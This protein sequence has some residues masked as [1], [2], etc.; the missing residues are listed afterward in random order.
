MKKIKSKKFLESKRKTL[1]DEKKLKQKV[2]KEEE[3]N[4]GWKKSKAKSFC[5]R[6]QVN[7]VSPPVE[8]QTQS[9]ITM[10]MKFL[11]EGEN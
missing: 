2:F 7:D 11:E 1:G 4:I 10:K 3:K 8:I 9:K 5:L 6:R